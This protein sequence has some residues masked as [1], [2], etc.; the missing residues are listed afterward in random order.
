MLKSIVMS[1]A[2]VSL[3]FV[4]QAVASEYYTIGPLTATGFGP[5][6][7]E[8]CD[9]ALDDMQDQI[10][11]LEQ[12]LPKDHTIIAVYTGTPDYDPPIC[13]IEFTVLVL[14]ECD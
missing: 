1:C 14:E 4:T 13:N 5:T 6:E 9:D 10:D 12:A 8:A 2:L 7:Q 11:I 3:I